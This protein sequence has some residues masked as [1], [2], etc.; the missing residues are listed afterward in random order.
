MIS[1]GSVLSFANPTIFISDAD[2]GPSNYSRSHPK[3]RPTNRVARRVVYSGQDCGSGSAWIH[4]K[5]SC[6][7]HV[8]KKNFTPNLKNSL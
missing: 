5:L 6:R 2:A 7:I 3:T 8:L 1:T 4:I